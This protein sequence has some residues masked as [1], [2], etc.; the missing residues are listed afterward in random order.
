MS[1]IK[2]IGEVY[3]EQAETGVHECEQ[4]WLHIKYYEAKGDS[5]KILDFGLVIFVT[6]RNLLFV[7]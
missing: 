3:L 2:D 7:I 5:I 1:V 4:S 6:V